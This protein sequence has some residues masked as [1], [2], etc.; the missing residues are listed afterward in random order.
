MILE[1]RNGGWWHWCPACRHKH[2]LPDEGWEFD[3][4]EHQP[5]FKPSFKQTFHRLQDPAGQ[6]VVCHYHITR[7]T[8]Q[9]CVDSWHGRS[10]VVI[11]P[12]IPKE[13]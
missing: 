3:G 2:P 13:A 11:M 1:R 10:D 9:F 12:A 7:G 6:T 8:I 4:D 5:T